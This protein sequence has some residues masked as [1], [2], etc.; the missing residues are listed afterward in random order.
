MVPS[1]TN[2]LPNASSLV[3]PSLYLFQHG[4]PQIR[5]HAPLGLTTKDALQ[6]VGNSNFQSYSRAY[7]LNLKYYPGFKNGT[8]LA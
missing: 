5:F 1:E 2:W 3:C 7:G 8:N 6:E 4:D